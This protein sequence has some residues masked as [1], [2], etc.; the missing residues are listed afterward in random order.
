MAMRSRSGD[1]SFQRQSERGIA[2][3]AR[4]PRSS[5]RR[6][7]GTVEIFPAFLIRRLIRALLCALRF[8]NGFAVYPAASPLAVFLGSRLTLNLARLGNSEVFARNPPHLFLFS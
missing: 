4:C 2:F 8:P 1:R 5:G 6:L 3:A 7:Q